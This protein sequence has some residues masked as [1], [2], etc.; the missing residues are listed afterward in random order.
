MEENNQT[1]PG[2]ITQAQ[3]KSWKDKYGEVFAIDIPVT[4]LT[5]EEIAAGKIAEQVT[6]YFRKPN[7]QI[8][9]M[10]AKIV[11]SDPIKAYRHQFDNCWLGG[12]PL[13]HSNEEVMYAAM[14]AVNALFKV[15]IASIKNL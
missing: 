9:G 4:D 3:L 11:D 10:A 1:L 2:G 13:F 8:I 15:R 7:L 14:L 5:K 12:D 6:G